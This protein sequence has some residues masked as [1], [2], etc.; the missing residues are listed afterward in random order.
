M[1]VASRPNIIILILAG[2]AVAVVAIVVLSQMPSV[3]T[4]GAIVGVAGTFLA[5]A[6]SVARELVS[7]PSRD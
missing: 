5:M 4:V 3:D 1:L 7:T 2:A 6:G